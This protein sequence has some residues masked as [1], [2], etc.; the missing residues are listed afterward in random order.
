MQKRSVSRS[1]FKPA[2]DHP[3]RPARFQY[4]AALLAFSTLWSERVSLWR[5][6]IT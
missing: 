1:S 3:S 5:H 4:I 2:P 6:A